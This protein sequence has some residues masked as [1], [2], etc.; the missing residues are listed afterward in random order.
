MPKTK[1]ERISK[2]EVKQ[3]AKLAAI[4]VSDGELIEF[5]QDLDSILGYIEILNEANIENVEPTSH[6]HGINNAFRDDIS[7][8]PLTSESIIEQAP[9]SSGTS[10]RVPRI[11]N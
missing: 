2:E 7:K 3:I 11:I 10:F 9:S 1:K 5:T 8:E 6:V 4:E